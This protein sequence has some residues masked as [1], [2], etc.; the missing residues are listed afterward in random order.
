MEL[1]PAQDKEIIF[2]RTRWRNYKLFGRRGI[3]WVA[4]LLQVS[5]E[6]LCG[7]DTE[8]GLWSCALGCVF[9]NNVLWKKFVSNID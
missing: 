4:E 2:L 7:F 1:D 6:R 5:Q 3:P 8:S 9:D